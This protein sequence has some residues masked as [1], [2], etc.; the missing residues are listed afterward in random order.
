LTYA[1]SSN[2]SILVERY[3]RGSAVYLTLMNES[4]TTN[5]A[6]ISFAPGS[7][8]INGTP[9]ATEMLSGSPVAITNNTFAV[10]INPGEVKVVKIV[11]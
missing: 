5:S 2:A 8:G 9:S 4:T 1:E 7:L 10:S 11:S 3:G 6:V